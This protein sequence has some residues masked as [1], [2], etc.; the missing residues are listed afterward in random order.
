MYAK[1]IDILRKVDNFK[2]SYPMLLKP[3]MHLFTHEKRNKF[4]RHF[5]SSTDNHKKYPIFS[6]IV[7]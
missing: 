7:E 2:A 3:L 1:D 6:D 4:Y 5:L